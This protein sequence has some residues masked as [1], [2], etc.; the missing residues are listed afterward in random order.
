M[1]AAESARKLLY[2]IKR[3]IKFTTSGNDKKES[4]DCETK[5]IGEVILW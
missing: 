2:V 5:K 3:K 1:F 4:D